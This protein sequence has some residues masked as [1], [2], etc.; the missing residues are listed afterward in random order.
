MATEQPTP[1]TSDGV[2]ANVRL[3]RDFVNTVDLQAAEESLG[4]P[5]DLHDWFVA[6][7]LARPGDRIGPKDL[8]VA[9]AVREG[10]RSV[11]TAHAGH[12]T[13]DQAIG[14]LN[15][16][17]ENVPVRVGFT[18]RG[19]HRLVA[20]DSSAFHSAL[21]GLLDAV[22]QSSAGQTWDR[23]KVCARDT[24]RWAFYD[25]SRNRAGR[26]CSMAGCGNYVKMQRAYAARKA[27][28]GPRT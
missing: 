13:D 22:R 9:H 5:Q 6:H 2:P 16:A 28:T 10:L 27:R 8:A 23:L 17:L 26:W 1:G 7:G 15:R 19:D 12:A 24:C 25:A 4:T 14:S 21:V 11:L 18:G 3:V 20:G